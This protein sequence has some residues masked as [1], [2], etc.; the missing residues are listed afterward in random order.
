MAEGNSVPSALQPRAGWARSSRNADAPSPNTITDLSQV[1]SS[2]YKAGYQPPSRGA[3]AGPQAAATSKSGWDSRFGVESGAFGK[4]QAATGQRP[5]SIAAAPTTAS[6]PGSIRPA[7]L[8]GLPAGSP[9]GGPAY[10]GAGPGST[11]GGSASSPSHP[12]RSDLA[13]SYVGKAY[14]PDVTPPRSRAGA[15]QAYERDLVSS[16]SCSIRPWPAQTPGYHRRLS[17]PGGCRGGGAAAGP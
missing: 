14:S 13:T 12:P 7:Q 5:P 15:R 16:S 17:G 11:E 8:P 6:E 9:R 3:S 2:G 10:F 4:D 1:T